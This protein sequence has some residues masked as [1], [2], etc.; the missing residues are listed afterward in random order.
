M[1]YRIRNIPSNLTVCKEEQTKKLS[2]I[3]FDKIFDCDSI[4][5]VPFAFNDK[6]RQYFDHFQSYQNIIK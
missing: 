3:Y 2:P 5:L 1:F 6:F 4:P